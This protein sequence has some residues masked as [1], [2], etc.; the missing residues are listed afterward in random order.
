MPSGGMLSLMNGYASTYGGPTSPSNGRIISQTNSPGSLDLYSLIP[1]GGSLGYIQQTTA[2]PQFAGTLIPTAFQNGFH[3]GSSEVGKLKRCA[4]EI[5]SCET[6][7]AHPTVPEAGIW[8]LL[9]VAW[10]IFLTWTYVRHCSTDKIYL[11]CC[12][13]AAVVERLDQESNIYIYIYISY[14]FL[15][16]MLRYQRTKMIIIDYWLVNFLMTFSVIDDWASN[17]KETSCVI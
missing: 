17:A 9:P 8:W 14:L 7:N 13:L 4:F 15:V 16:C 2:S 10:Q 1:D 3:W 12:H 11:T 6:E 5:F